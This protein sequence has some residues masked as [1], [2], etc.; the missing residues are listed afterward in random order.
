MP[1]AIPNTPEMNEVDSTDAV[2]A[3]TNG[4]LIMARLREFGCPFHGG[5]DGDLANGFSWGTA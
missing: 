5:F 4:M 1:P 2:S 3:A